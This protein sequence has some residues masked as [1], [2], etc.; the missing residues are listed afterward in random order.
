MIL[1]KSGSRDDIEDKSDFDD[2]LFDD[3]ANDESGSG[4]EETEQESGDNEDDGDNG[5]DGDNGDD[6]DNVT[7][8]TREKSDD[9]KFKNVSEEV[10]NFF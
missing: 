1:G 2:G 6:G 8:E 10:R 5:N 7:G 3:L 4:S 9:D